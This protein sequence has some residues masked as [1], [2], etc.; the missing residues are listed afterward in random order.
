M[1]ERIFRAIS[2]DFVRK[3]RNWARTRAGLLHGVTS[4]SIYD[5]PIRVDRSPELMIPLLEGDAQDVTYGLQQLPARYRQA[6]ELFWDMEGASLRR[7]A[8]RCGKH[9]VNH[10][11][12][13]AWVIKGHELLRVELGA[14]IRRC[15]AR[16]DQAR[17]LGAGA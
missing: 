5:G 8:K 12:F 1:S 17:A 16:A 3:M 15:R 9:G 10:E 4:T 7:L 11:T 14:H 2:D 13:E 6:V